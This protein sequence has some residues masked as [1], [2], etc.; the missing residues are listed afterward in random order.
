M[1]GPAL[2][3][4]VDWGCYGCGRL[5]EQGL[6]IKSY[7]SGDELV[8]NWQPSEF[9]IGHPDNLHHGVT[10]TIMFCHGAW[11]A[12]AMAY[13]KEGREFEKAVEYFYVNRRLQFDVLKP[14]PITSTVTF[15]AIVDQLTDE[16]A[17]V[18]STASVGDVDCAIGKTHL[19]RVSAND[20]EF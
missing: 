9:H 16:N 1:Q 2:Q 12:T 3:D 7:W 19:E 10:A 8:C 5:N 17:D 14:I 15:K 11:A 13:R 6:Q 18:S 20:M 4:L